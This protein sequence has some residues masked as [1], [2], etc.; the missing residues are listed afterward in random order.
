MKKNIIY[1]YSTDTYKYKKWYKIGET[2]QD[3]ACIRVSQQ[4]GTSNPEKLE[5]LFEKD[6]SELTNLTAFDVEQKLHKS[7]SKN[8]VR[9]EWFEIE[10]GIDE[11]KN[12][13]EIILDNT[14]LFKNEI[15]LKPHQVE[16]NNKINN[17]FESDD[18]KC[19][20]FNKPRSGKT[21]TTLY[22]IIEHKYDN[23]IILTSYPI[24]NYQWED[25]ISNSKGFLNT[26]IIIGTDVE[27]ITL[28]PN[29]QSIIFLSLQD[30]KGGEEI[31]GKEKFNSIQDIQFDL[32]VIDEVHYGVETEKTY[33]FLKKIKYTRLLGLSATPTKNLLC[34]TFTNDKIHNYTINNEVELKKEYPNLYPYPTIN[35]L[36]WNLS[37]NEKKDLEFFSDEEQ[38]KFDKFFRI[39]NGNF[40]YN[41]DI[42]HL[43][44]KLSGDIDICKKDKLGTS[45]P[46]KN[47]QQY[48][49][50]KSILLFLP[51][52]ESQYKLKELLKDLD[53]YNNFNI[54]ITNSKENS[55]KKL[56]SKINREY[57]SN[58]KQTLILAVDQL[59]TGITLDDCDM[60]V[61]MNDWKSVDKYIQ[62]SF[63][64]QSPRKDKE[65]CWVLDLNPARSFDIMWEYQRIIS[66]NSGESISH[67][68]KDWIGCVNIFNR[69]DGELKL[70]D[71][72]SFNDEYSKYILDKP[73]FNYNSVIYTNKLLE[74]K[75][76]LLRLNY[77][78]STYTSNESL[79]KDGV[80]EGKS[81]NN[82]SIEKTTDENIHFDE[83]KLIE[84][85]KVLVDKTFLLSIFTNYKFDNI[86]KCFNELEED[87]SLKEMYLSIILLGVDDIQNVYLNT[88]KQIYNILFDKE[89]INKKIELFNLKMKTYISSIRENSDNIYNMLPRIIEMINSYLKPSNTEKKLLGEVFTPLY[90]KTGCVNNQ[91]NLID[92]TFW[93]YK[94]VKVLDPCAGIGNYSVVLIEK[95]MDGLIDEIPNEEERLKW[96]L[97]EII[98]I[99]EYQS[100]NLFIY[101]QLFDSENKYDMNF[102]KGD[103]LT[104][105]IKETFGVDNFDLIC[106]N[107]P[108]QEMD[109]GYKASSMPL[110]NKFIEK[111][112]E[113]S[114]K[115]VSINP[116]RWFAGGKGLD[117]FRKFMLNNK[118]IKV[119]K[120]I[121]N[122]SDVF[123]NDVKIMSG[124]SYMFIDKGHNGECLV[125]GIFKDLSKHDILITDKTIDSVIDKVNIF[126]SISNICNSTNYFGIDYRQG[127]GERL[128]DIMDIDHVKVYV[129]KNKGSVKYIHKSYLKKNNSKYLLATPDGGKPGKLTS[130]FIVKPGEYT[131]DAFITFELN[132]EI[133]STSFYSYLNT[134]FSK[135]M[136]S[137]RKIS[138]HI[139]PSTFK[140]I[141]IVP[142]DREWTDEKLFE[143]F[144]LN[145]E[146][147]KIIINYGEKSNT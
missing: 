4:D 144:K 86:D 87:K 23:I 47:N 108:Y 136:I 37:N 44:K 102:N 25:I 55:S 79:N 60:V 133:E 51:N 67:C 53:S 72:N 141:P 116:S 84:I 90:G 99:N 34:G 48:S 59:T 32:L 94:N 19:L 22:H 3:S 113:D 52:I 20:L 68:I 7:F 100:K 12:R 14:D 93:T 50:I 123:G 130:M 115:V 103:Y 66:N 63:R 80:Y 38:F 30:V 9:K 91:L 110:Y 120:H 43:F 128:K 10:N 65:N 70:I 76:Y 74:A 105:D 107:P 124:V 36:I 69:I 117:K 78:K 89:I 135:Y 126:E 129:T 31:F 15:I 40:Y 64:G 88:I 119:I 104:L 21:Y 29:K 61:L 71:V 131:S 132:S 127:R 6:I 41:N 138:Q 33:E 145:K 146:E 54:H 27:K 45:Y 11:I 139:N 92:D 109:G 142:F 85:A 18:K 83:N 42:I 49:D 58:N 114:D 17:C 122:A 56:L 26:E 2:T 143:Y 28:N 137:L 125:N 62:A 73:R 98:Y 39:E 121:D 140:W 77:N 112:I 111:A 118:N 75:E 1:V 57:K 97:E 13:L 35:F 5:L 81:K 24:L 134:N 8:K 95:F 16:G 46:F 147:E 101:L 82:L 106:M 96:I